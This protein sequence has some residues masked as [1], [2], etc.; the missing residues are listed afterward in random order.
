MIEPGPAIRLQRRYAGHPSRVVIISGS[1]SP[2]S[3]TA[4]MGEY[5]ASLLEADGISVRHLQVRDISPAALL[6]ADCSDAGVVDAL[7]AVADADGVVLATPTFKAAYSG[8]LK[9]FLDL[10][11]QFGFAGKA[12]LPLATG[13]SLAHVLALDYALRPVIQSM[14]ARHV[15]QSYF[16]LADQLT[17]IDGQFSLQPQLAAV[18]SDVVRDFRIALAPADPI[19]AAPAVLKS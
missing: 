7:G 1:P 17:V 15:V 9:V 11:P 5:V 8:L 13:G 12:V 16:V 6:T 18:L 4:Q 19:A 2:T 14:G 10:L 3:K